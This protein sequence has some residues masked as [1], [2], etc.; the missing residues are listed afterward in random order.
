ML[1]GPDRW[2]GFV[3]SRYNS[4]DGDTKTVESNSKLSR[5]DKLTTE[6]Y[7]YENIL[8]LRLVVFSLRVLVVKINITFSLDYDSYFQKPIIPKHMEINSKLILWVI[9]L[10]S[11]NWLDIIA[12][13][14]VSS[15]GK[16]NYNGQ[17]HLEFSH[18]LITESISPDT[19]IRLT[20]LDTKSNDNILSQTY[21]LEL[22]Y[23]PVPSFSIHLDVPYVVLHPSGN[24]I[25]SNLDEI[26]LALKFANFAFASHNVLLGYGIIFG[27]PTGDQAKGIG[28]NHI[29]DINPFFNGGIKWERWEWT[30][31]FI[32]GIPS[33]QRTN[34][35]IQ[36]GLESRLT[37][38]Y[39]I[40]T[41]WGALLEAGNATQISR[42]YKGDN[43][44]DLTEGI[45]F[46][47]DPD[48]PWII[49][50][51]ARNP[52]FKNDE[53]K[54]QGMVSVFYHFKD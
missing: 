7:T 27:L 26:E 23:A 45:I 5:Y 50:I 49:G 33:N 36:T 39:N 43:S 46:R 1:S 16:E 17:E 9:L 32:F 25:I 28:N 38:L 4:Q 34:E 41:R 12:Q 3:M 6:T 48:K 24:N 35:N 20:F 44:Y 11:M 30:A 2:A 19:K 13:E 29:L 40:N 52:I 21:D 14:D 42:F 54:L 37:A 8:H 15:N 18:P 10:F 51:G 53:I 47:P 31:F 22:E